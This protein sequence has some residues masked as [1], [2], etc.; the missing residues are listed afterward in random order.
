M[1]DDL[2]SSDFGSTVGIFDNLDSEE[3]KDTFIEKNFN[4]TNLVN[5]DLYINLNFKN[6]SSIVEGSKLNLYTENKQNLYQNRSKILHP[7]NKLLVKSIDLEADSSYYIING[8]EIIPIKT[9]EFKNSYGEFD[10]N[11]TIIK[12]KIRTTKFQILVLMNQFSG[13]I[14]LEIVTIIQKAHHPLRQGN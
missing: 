9:D 10:D 13:K 6:L 12:T 5:H 7:I 1:N 8:E 3:I 11:I 14:R 4:N 2:N